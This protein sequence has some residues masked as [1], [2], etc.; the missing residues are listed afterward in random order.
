[1]SQALRAYNELVDRLLPPEDRIKFETVIGSMLSGGPPK[2]V[3]FYGPEGSGKT[4]LMRIIKRLLT[5]SAVGDGTARVAFRRSGSRHV[6]EE[7]VFNSF[8]F[9]DTNRFPEELPPGDI[10][11]QTTGERL[12]VNKYYVLMELIDYELD[13][14]AEHCIRTYENT[15][16]NNR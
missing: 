4:T 16:G 2:H 7:M 3:L 12:P 10:L 14:I 9:A 13:A 5:M 6:N 15:L 11:L 1:M 8:V